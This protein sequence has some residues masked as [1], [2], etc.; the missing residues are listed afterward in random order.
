M[1]RSAGGGLERAWFDRLTMH[2]IRPPT[3]RSFRSAAAAAP[4]RG[5]ARPSPLTANPR[6]WY[7]HK[8][9]KFVEMEGKELPGVIVP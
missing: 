8:L 2:G 1:S 3:M 5:R 6:K 4:H 7:I 9:R